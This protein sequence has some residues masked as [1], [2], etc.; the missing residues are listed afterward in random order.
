MAFKKMLK[1]YALLILKQKKEN[2]T[3][4]IKT[5]SLKK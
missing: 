5:I 3:K 2:K 4:I 1:R